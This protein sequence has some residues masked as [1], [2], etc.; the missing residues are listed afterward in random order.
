MLGTC[1]YDISEKNGVAK[2]NIEHFK[3]KKARTFYFFC[4]LLVYTFMAPGKNC[5]GIAWVN[6]YLSFQKGIIYQKMH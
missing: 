3:T 4:F 1:I 2:F 5:V 6:L